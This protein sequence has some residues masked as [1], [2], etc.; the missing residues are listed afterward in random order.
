MSASSPQG[1]SVGPSAEALM[2]SEVTEISGRDASL[3]LGQIAPRHTVRGVSRISDKLTT[4]VQKVKA[5]DGGVGLAIPEDDAITV[6][7]LLRAARLLDPSLREESPTSPPSPLRQLTRNLQNGAIWLSHF[8]AE[9]NLTEA[10]DVIEYLYNLGGRIEAEMRGKG[11]AFAPK[12]LDEIK[13]LHIAYPESV[14]DEVA[15]NGYDR[16]MMFYLLFGKNI[17]LDPQSDGPVNDV[18][19]GTVYEHLYKRWRENQQKPVAES[20]V[21]MQELASTQD[22]PADSW[23]LRKQFEE[24]YLDRFINA[25]KLDP[26]QA[27]ALIRKSLFNG[28]GHTALFGIVEGGALEQFLGE[29]VM[30]VGRGH[31]TEN[32]AMPPKLR[33]SLASRFNEDYA[34]QFFEQFQ[35]GEGEVSK[36]FE[37]AREM[38]QKHEALHLSLE[39][40]IDNFFELVRGFSYTES[41]LH[42]G[43]AHAVET[44]E[45]NCTI[46]S[47]LL[48][49]LLEEY[50]G[51]KL[52]IFGVARVGHVELLVAEKDT[53]NPQKAKEAFGLNANTI[54]SRERIE[55]KPEDT[56]MLPTNMPIGLDIQQ[57]KPLKDA[58]GGKEKIVDREILDVIDEAIPFYESDNPQFYHIPQRTKSGTTQIGSWQRMVAASIVGNFAS[59]DL[60]DEGKAAVAHSASLL[61]PNSSTLTILGASLR[62]LGLEEYAAPYLEKA[63]SLFPDSLSAWRELGLQTEKDPVRSRGYLLKSLELDTANDASWLNM[64][65]SYLFAGD[66]DTARRC[67]RKAVVLNPNDRWNWFNVA[68]SYGSDYGALPAT[69]DEFIEGISAWEHALALGSEDPTETEEQKQY[70]TTIMNRMKEDYDRFKA[71]H[72]S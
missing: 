5:M 48:G 70:Y 13:A 56:S 40:Q 9:R 43:F 14:T 36:L 23:R 27:V 2:Q 44:G 35:L 53:Q 18:P 37:R 61:R 3:I 55:K 51:D 33:E 41:V 66:A 34:K 65:N 58:F 62:N 64:G 42:A 17:L 6:E 20:A 1:E 72:V 71:T 59:I 68:V 50:L 19:E 57:K 46:K 24:E 10:T 11:N 21:S 8:A 25:L 39:Q 67:Y 45:F 54:Y 4:R 49:T 7:E 47:F 12:T 28:R 16:E 38:A 26:Q 15:R 52:Y 22:I 63:V 69:N 30:R 60:S 32:L 31:I 29:A